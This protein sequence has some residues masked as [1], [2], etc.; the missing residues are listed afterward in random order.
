MLK[1]ESHHEKYMLSIYFPII[2]F[3]VSIQLKFQ[4]ILSFLALH[5]IYKIVKLFSEST[6]LNESN[7][8]NI[9]Y[10]TVALRFFKGINF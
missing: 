2:L 4:I 7:L 3:K 5:E 9:F 10:T 6:N 8:S 1:F